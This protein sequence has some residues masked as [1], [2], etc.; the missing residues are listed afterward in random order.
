MPSL[1]KV[2]FF[3]VAIAT[4]T[5]PAQDSAPAGSA[6]REA[7]ATPSPQ[8]EMKRW[9]ED[10]DEQWRAIRTKE[11]TAPYDLEVGKTRQRYL[12]SVETGLAKATSAGDLEAV[13]VWRKERDQFSTAKD[14]VTEGEQNVPAAI[15]QLRLA[16]K[17]EID[18]L[19]KDRDEKTK[20]VLARYDAALAKAQALL[21]QRTR[22][23]DALL[24]KNRREQIATTWAP[25]VAEAPAAASTEQ[26]APSVTTPPVPAGPPA[27]RRPLASVEV[28]DAGIL[29]LVPDEK[30]WSDRD[31]KITEIPPTFAGLQ[32]TQFKA[33]GLTLTFKV[34][35]DGLVYLGCSARWGATAAAEV[36]KSFMTAEKLEKEGWVREEAYTIKTTARDMS[37]L[38]YSRM[39]KAGE[40]FSYRTEKYAPPI[41]LME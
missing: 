11:V 6:G 20:G 27:N 10:L 38:I 31:V 23:D 1:S 32:F 3:A 26:K 5:A 16:W 15:K 21:T 35:T 9:L 18:R 39:C 24:V 4:C 33:H 8:A 19:I 28:Q 25:G 14:I 29:K 34:K 22:I 36:A 40:E 17:A 7:V 12:A 13:L 30:V 37:F 2:A 41:L